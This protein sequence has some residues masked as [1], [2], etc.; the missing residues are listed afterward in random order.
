MTK[1]CII[2]DKEAVYKI[3]DTPDY[4][5]QEC[6]EDSFSDLNV[7]VKIEEEARKLKAFL[8]EKM[9]D[10]VQKEDEL[11]KILVVKEK[12]TEKEDAQD[13]QTGKD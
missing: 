12:K 10:L 11:D 6:A 1:K 9:D 2:C 5:C 3:K 4:Y 8:K 13:D 7:L